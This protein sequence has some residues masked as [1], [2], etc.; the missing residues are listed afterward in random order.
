MPTTRH[1]V[2]AAASASLLL[3]RA[4]TPLRA[5]V[6]QVWTTLA[7]GA[8]LAPVQYQPAPGRG[9]E[10]G[11]RRMPRRPNAGGNGWLASAVR[12]DVSPTSAG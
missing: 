8:Q 3:A 10:R 4:A 7:S 1:A 5:Q 12:A 11:L 9:T 2:A 6:A